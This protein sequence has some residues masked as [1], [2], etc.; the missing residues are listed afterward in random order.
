MERSWPAHQ[1]GEQKIKGIFIWL[2]IF[3]C[4]SWL[5]DEPNDHRQRCQNITVVETQ[6][7]EKCLNYGIGLQCDVEYLCTL[8]RASGCLARESCSRWR[9][10]SFLDFPLFSPRKTGNISKLWK[11][12]R[13]LTIKK[14]KISQISKKE[15]PNNL[16]LEKMRENIT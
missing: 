3:V 12:N 11:F 15:H 4:C 7:H 2:V 13:G 14:V 5:T 16:E 1:F 9:A 6:S 10:F 8:K